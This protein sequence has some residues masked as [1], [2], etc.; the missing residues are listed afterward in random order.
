[1]KHGTWTVVFP[2]KRIIKKTDDFT[3]ETGRGYVI[4]DDA[5]YGRQRTIWTARRTSS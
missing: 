1:M 3:V 5:F 4:D 2:D